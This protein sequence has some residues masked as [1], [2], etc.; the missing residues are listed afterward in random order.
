MLQSKDTVLLNAK[1]K[2]RKKQVPYIFWLQET[3]FMSKDTDWKWED[4]EVFHVNGNKKE[5]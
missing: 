3:D 4:G 2:E 5:S 1:K